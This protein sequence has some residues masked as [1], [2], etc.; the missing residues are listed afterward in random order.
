METAQLGFIRMPLS[1]TLLDKQTNGMAQASMKI[2]K[3]C[4]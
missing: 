2:Y 3:Y 4:T 1:L